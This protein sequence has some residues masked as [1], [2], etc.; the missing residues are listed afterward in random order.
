MVL[1]EYR[2]KPFDLRSSLNQGDDDA[3]RQRGRGEGSGEKQSREKRVEAR[4]G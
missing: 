1:E 3:V 4:Q 2:V